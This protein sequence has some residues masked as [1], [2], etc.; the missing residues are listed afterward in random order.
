LASGFGLPVFCCLLPE[1]APLQLGF[2]LAGC[3]SPAG[4]AGGPCLVA[5]V[6]GFELLALG[7]QVAGERLG[8]C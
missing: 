3:F 7:G 4:R 6:G 1:S 8:A 2:G 5:G